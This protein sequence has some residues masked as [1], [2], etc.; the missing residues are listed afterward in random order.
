MVIGFLLFCHGT[1]KLLGLWGGHKMPLLS[2]FGLAGVLETVG[3][4]LI[5]LGLFTR[6]AA[7]ILCGELA[8]AYFTDACKA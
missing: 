1:Q 5:V 7:F 8:V 3:G 6:F 4:V 2:L